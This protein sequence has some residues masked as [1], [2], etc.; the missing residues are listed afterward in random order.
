LIFS[1]VKTLHFS[2]PPSKVES[3]EADNRTEQLRLKARQMLKN[4]AASVIDSEA[5]LMLER[6]FNLFLIPD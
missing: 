3:Q 1:D 5:I 4:P 2:K 6:L